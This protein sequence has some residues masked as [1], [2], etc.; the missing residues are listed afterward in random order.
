V[1]SAETRSGLKWNN[2]VSNLLSFM[3]ELEVQNLLQI[4]IQGFTSF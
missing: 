1:K 3:C 2:S 4:I